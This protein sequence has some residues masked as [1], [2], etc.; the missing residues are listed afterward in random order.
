MATFT[1]VLPLYPLSGLL[2]AD[3]NPSPEGAEQIGNMMECQK[4][5]AALLKESG[6]LEND[7]RIRKVLGDFAERMHAPSSMS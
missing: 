4:K 5:V 7:P 6:N 2:G 1:Q 3:G